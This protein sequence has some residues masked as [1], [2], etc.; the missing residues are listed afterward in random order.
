[1]FGYARRLTAIPLKLLLVYHF[2]SP[3]PQ[4]IVRGYNT[5]QLAAYLDV[6]KVC[7]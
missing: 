4:G 5:T 6:S 3:N 2:G 7:S 1:M